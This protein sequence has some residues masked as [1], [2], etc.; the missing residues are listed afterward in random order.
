VSDEKP[1]TYTAGVWALSKADP[2]LG[3]AVATVDFQVGTATAEKQIV[4]KEQCAACHLGADSGKF[5]FHH[6]DQG[7]PTGSNWS[8][9][10]APVTF[11]KTCHNNDGYS[12]TLDVDGKT[13]NP[14]PIVKK[15]HGVHM[16]EE[17]SNPANIDPATGLFKDYTS[18]V[19]PANVKNCVACH[20]DDRWKPNPGSP[21]GPATTIDRHGQIG[22]SGKE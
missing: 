7:A 10:S 8:L 6:V 3:Q 4:A 19:F 16:G 1:G 15:V 13:R 17:L 21:A 9:D 14:S 2:V 11:C 12:S 22:C 18:V 5:Y 20:V